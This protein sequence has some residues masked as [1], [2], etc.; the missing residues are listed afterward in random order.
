MGMIR[1]SESCTVMDLGLDFSPVCTWEQW[2][3][4]G[5][6]LKTVSRIYNRHLRFW[7]GDWIN[8]G[9][10]RFPRKYT[11]ALDADLYSIGALRNVS[12][13]C[14]HVPMKNR[15]NDLSFDHHATVAKLDDEKQIH[16]LRLASKNAWTVRQLREAVAGRPIS[17]HAVP[18]DGQWS[19]PPK[20]DPITFDAWW[21]EQGESMVESEESKELCR[22]VAQAAWNARP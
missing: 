14:R 4:K 15:R 8:F 13:V 1:T 21:S 7:L 19:P 9:E 3:R 2:D 12:W 18:E 22:S 5:D 6:E 17:T 16:F 20:S 10:E 11:Q